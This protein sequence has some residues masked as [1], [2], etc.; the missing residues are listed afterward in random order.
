MWLL[1]RKSNSFIIVSHD[2]DLLNKCCNKILYVNDKK[3]KLYHGNYDKFFEK[4]ELELEELMKQKEKNEKKK[5]RLK[6]QI[7]KIKSRFQHEISKRGGPVLRNLGTGKGSAEEAIVK[8][9]K[10]IKRKTDEMDKVE[11]IKLPK[12]E[13]IKINYLGNE[14]SYTKVLEI[15]NLVKILDDFTLK[16]KHFKIERGEKIGIIG[17]NGSGKTTLFKLIL[18][19]M[20]K[21]SGTIAIGNRVKMGYLSQ[22]NEVLNPEKTVFEEL[23]NIN[24]DFNETNVR[25]YLAKFLF[26][27]NEIYKKVKDLSGGEK[28][29]ISLLKLILQGCNLLLLD[30]PS[31]HLDIKSKDILADSLKKFVG[32]TLIISHDMHFLK[33]FTNRIIDVENLKD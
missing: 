24:L 13:K 31:N 1:E 29:R 7:D 27:E 2:V 22:K 14:K 23:E 5:D 20:Q 32:T 17:K 18:N 21:D 25:N 16:I 30:E 3:I 11:D 19:K 12:D 15:E 10:L 9:Q 26:R 8:A 4:K 6:D 33:Q 28:I